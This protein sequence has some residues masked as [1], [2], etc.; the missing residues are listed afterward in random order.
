ME[1]AAAIIVGLITLLVAWLKWYTGRDT[2]YADLQI[3][4]TD[5]ASGNVDAVAVR[6]DRL[7]SDPD[8]PAGDDIADEPSAENFEGRISR[9]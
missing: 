2:T 7:L 4:R 9:L 6:I 8:N 5:I 1:A 3:G